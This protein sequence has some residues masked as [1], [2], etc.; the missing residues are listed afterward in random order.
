MT[1]EETRADDLRQQHLRESDLPITPWRL[2][3]PSEQDRWRRRA[4]EESPNGTAAH[5]PSKRSGFTPAS[6]E[7]RAAIKDRGSIVSGEQPCDGAHLT[8]RALGGCN[9]PLCVV[10]L[11]RIEHRAFDDGK[12]DILPYLYAH[13]LYDEIAHA[14]QEHHLDLV[15]LLQRLTGVRW[16]PETT[17]TSGHKEDPSC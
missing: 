11:T 1:N 17:S 3:D 12:L 15:S 8:P 9:H 13:G 7:Q 14:I 6:R 16:A 4:R 5:A 10:P 2:V